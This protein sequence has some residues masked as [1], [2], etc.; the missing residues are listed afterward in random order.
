MV[1]MAGIEPARPF[2][3]G[4]LSP[5]RLPFRHIRYGVSVR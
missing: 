4:I 1:R 5:L 3:Q 2:G